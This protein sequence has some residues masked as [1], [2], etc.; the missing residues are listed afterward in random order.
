MK[1][2]KPSGCCGGLQCHSKYRNSSKAL[3]LSTIVSKKR[4]LSMSTRNM[5]TVGHSLWA[6]DDIKILEQRLGHLISNS[7]TGGLEYNIEQ[8]A[9]GKTVLPVR[10]NWSKSHLFPR[11]PN[12]RCCPRAGL[13]LRSVA[14]GQF[15]RPLDGIFYRVPRKK[16][17]FWP[18]G[19]K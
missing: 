16:A 13:E 7:E 3:P 9:W 15:W 10:G 6:W 4:R 18:E 8:G 2:L 17:E 5:R 19:R 12:K 11:G 1:E 14:L